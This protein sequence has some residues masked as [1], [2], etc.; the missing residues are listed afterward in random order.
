MCPRKWHLVFFLKVMD[1][2]APS[3][4]SYVSSVDIPEELEVV[5]FNRSS[6]EARAFIRMFMVQMR[7]LGKS[8]VYS[9]D[10][11]SYFTATSFPVILT[12]YIP[13]PYILLMLIMC[14]VRCTTGRTNCRL[15]AGVKRISIFLE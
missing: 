5:V 7:Q 14:D 12:N 8:L 4:H 13:H 10:I 9:M 11:V 3:L 2:S 15:I 6:I 1:N